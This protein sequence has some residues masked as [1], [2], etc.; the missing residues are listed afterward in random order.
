[1]LCGVYTHAVLPHLRSTPICTQA[2]EYNSTSRELVRMYI[3]GPKANIL[4]RVTALSASC[5]CRSALSIQKVCQTIKCL[6]IFQIF[7]FNNCEYVWSRLCY[8]VT[9]Q[10]FDTV[11]TISERNKVLLQKM[12]TTAPMHLDNRSVHGRSIAPE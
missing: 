6:L 12:K 8:V 1:M 9:N 2:S 11:W 5:G 10:S 3:E 4:A 7:F